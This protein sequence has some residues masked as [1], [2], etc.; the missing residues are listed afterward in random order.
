[1]FGKFLKTPECMSVLSWLL[2]H[3]DNKYSAAIIAIECDMVDMSTFM[4]VLTILEGVDLIEFD[5]FS[6]EELM[7]GL[8]SDSSSTQLLTHLKEEFND[9]AF[10]SEQVSPSL[11][12]LHSPQ[13]KKTV[14]SQVL[15]RFE[16]DELI[17]KCKNYKDL[18]L[19]NEEEK[20]IYDI[21]SKLE[22][23][24][25]YEEFISKLEGSRSQ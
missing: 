20:E 7:I 9:C 14:D 10:N 22:E 3:P 16:A 24:G 17:N 21:C 13:L 23:T 2:S 8:K 25:E 5:E 6:K 4:A 15:E 18:D 1:M 12:Y 19:E 11:A